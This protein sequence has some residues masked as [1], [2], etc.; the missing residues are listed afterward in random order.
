[1]S[2]V[3]HHTPPSKSGS[4]SSFLLVGNA[5]YQNR[6][7]E[8]I[9]RGTVNILGN[10]ATDP[11]TLRF[12]SAFYGTPDALA[13]Q[14]KSETDKRISHLRVEAA[15]P[16]FTRAWWE[17]RFNERLGTDFPG[18]SKPLLASLESS[19]CALE[20]GGDNYTLDYGFPEHLIRMDRWLSSQGVPVVIWGASIG[21][22]TES[23][24][25]ESRMMEHL[26]S[27]DGVFVRESV[28]YDYLTKEHRLKNVSLFADSAFL[29]EQREP[30]DE[31]V[32]AKVKDSPLAFNMS[33]LLSAY[34]TTTRKMPWETKAEDLVPRIREC[35]E[36]VAALR[37]ETQLPILLLPHVQSPLPGI[38]D[39]EFLRGVHRACK[40]ADILGI[41]IVDEPLGARELK[42]L[43][44]RCRMVIAARTHATIAG[45]STCVPTISLGYSRKAVGINRDVFGTEDYLVMAR[46][47]EPGSIVER[48]RHL[49]K[50]EAELRQTLPKRAEELKRSAAAAGEKLRQILA[51]RSSKS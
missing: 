51:A 18:V 1:M 10:V 37:K 6:G 47:I 5:S 4:E 33:P 16:R 14:Q 8:A 39:Y 3:K 20:V 23:P 26:R 46:D 42:W 25:Y 35:A 22:F 44:A 40:D 12:T 48:A 17:T 49:L 9:V 11:E 31:A 36:I 30:V 28:T 19:C 45:F 7:C 41:E 2:S 38:D 24:V 29:M 34:T 27:L 43:I 15:P 50:H 21:P 32:R 13:A